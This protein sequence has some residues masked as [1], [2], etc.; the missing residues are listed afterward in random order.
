MVRVTLPTGG[1]SASIIGKRLICRSAKRKEIVP[2]VISELAVIG[3]LVMMLPAV[4]L[5]KS[6]L[7]AS[8]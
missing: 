1:P 8:E 7:S 4:R 2:M 3:G 5:L 6:L